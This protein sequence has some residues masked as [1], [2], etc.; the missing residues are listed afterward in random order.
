M[1][2]PGVGAELELRLPA[3]AAATAT[4]DPS[5]I[6]NLLRSLQQHRSLNPMSKAGIEL[7]S[8]WILV[9]FVNR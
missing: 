1:E 4:T 2:I 9:G 7:A 3:Y 8:F 5:C 6:C